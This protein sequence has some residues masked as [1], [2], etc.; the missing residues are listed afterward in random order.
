MGHVHDLKPDE[1]AASQLAVNGQ[2]EQSK[3]SGAAGQ[4]EANSNRPDLMQLQW[5]LLPDQLALVPGA[6]L[7]SS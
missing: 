5:R 1:I 4:L 3:V 6:L 2:I 7:V